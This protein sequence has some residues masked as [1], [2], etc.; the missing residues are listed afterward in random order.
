MK[1]YTEIYEKYDK[2]MEII[3]YEDQFG[4]KHQMMN[5]NIELARAEL[6]NDSFLIAVIYSKLKSEML[7][8]YGAELIDTAEAIVKILKENLFL[9]T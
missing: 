3:D 8:Q 7:K 1:D 4:Y 6:D 9:K 2:Y 5:F